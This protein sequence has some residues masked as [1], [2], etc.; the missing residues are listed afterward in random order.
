MPF[1]QLVGDQPVFTLITEI[2]NGNKDEFKKIVPVFGS[3]PLEMAFMN[4]ISSIKDLMAVDY[5]TLLSLL[6]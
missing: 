5:P 3:F 1:I 2:T 4:T 6:V